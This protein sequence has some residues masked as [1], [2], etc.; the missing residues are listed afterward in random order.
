VISRRDLLKGAA[1]A[2]GG[3]VIGKG[4]AAA[5]PK[6]PPRLVVRRAAER[7]HA[8]HGWLDTWHS[9]SFASYH[10]PR[11]E[12]FRA[13]RVINEDWIAP[14]TGFP[15][16]PHRDMEIVTYVLEGALEHKDSTGNGGV[17]RPGEVQRMSAGRGIRHSEFNASKRERVHLLQIWIL[18]EHAG[19]PPSYD[20]RVYSEADRRDR[21]R[22]VA[23]R[24]GRD[25]SISIRRDANVH[26]AI[27]SPGRR[28]AHENRPGR[29][30][31]LQVARGALTVGGTPLSAGDGASTSDP[32]TLD[33]VA[34]P[35]GTEVLLFDLD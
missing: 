19:G 16:H 14:G 11:H 24:D 22:L 26:A 13:L 4:E 8:N 15:T 29:H 20:Q 25:G 12:G 7:G 1:A 6:A 2:A 9:F 31:W 18:P 32:G 34:G 5:A 33:L 3:A 23:S 28:V 30:V 35:A 17:I 27:L 21:L 10:D